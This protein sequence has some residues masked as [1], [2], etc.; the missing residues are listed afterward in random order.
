MHQLR[1][2]HLPLSS[3]LSIQNRNLHVNGRSRQESCPLRYSA[4]HG[5]IQQP[6]K[7]DDL[8]DHSVYLDL[9]WQTGPPRVGACHVQT[10]SRR[11]LQIES[12]SGPRPSRLVLRASEHNKHLW[13][14]IDTESGTTA[15]LH[16]RSNL[17]QFRATE[18]V[19]SQWQ[20]ETASFAHPT[21]HCTKEQRRRWSCKQSK[22]SRWRG[23]I[24]EAY[25]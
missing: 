8:H 14:H 11:D 7:L 10:A 24:W 5:S 3:P 15:I 18:L 22:W 23:R 4:L 2:H 16:C 25:P 13:V 12:P 6:V 17:F 9:K 20:L 1:P 19:A 21:A